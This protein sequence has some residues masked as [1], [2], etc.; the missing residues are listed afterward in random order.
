MIKGDPDLREISCSCTASGPLH[1]SSFAVCLLQS[2][3]GI[4]SLSPPTTPVPPQMSVLLC[5]DGSRIN[6]GRSKS[7]LGQAGSNPNSQ[8]PAT[9][10]G[11]VLTCWSRSQLLKARGGR[12]CLCSAAAITQLAS[13]KG[14]AVLGT[15]EHGPQKCLLF[16]AQG[17]LIL[18]RNWVDGKNEM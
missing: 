6:L 2:I 18:I 15:K 17:C 3:P 16:K 10:T 4:L 9:W 8:F 14:Q 1:I 7:F 12:V 13:S 5:N 11:A